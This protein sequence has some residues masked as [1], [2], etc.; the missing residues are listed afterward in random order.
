MAKCRD[1]REEETALEYLGTQLGITVRLTPKFHA[2]LAGECIEYSWASE[3][4]FCLV[5]FQGLVVT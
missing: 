4:A 3:G 2:E 5:L 1:F